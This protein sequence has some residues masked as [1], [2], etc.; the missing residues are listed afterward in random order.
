MFS[1]IKYKYSVF[2]YVGINKRKENELCQ[3]NSGRGGIDYDDYM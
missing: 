2:L 3:N 1:I